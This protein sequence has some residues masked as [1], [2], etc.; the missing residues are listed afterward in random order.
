LGERSTLMWDMLMKDSSI[1]EMF[2][3]QHILC[4]ID[5][6]HG[7]SSTSLRKDEKAG[8]NQTQAAIAKLAIDVKLLHYLS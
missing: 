4:L 6:M 8:K 3:T 2:Q 1:K 5:I 7:I